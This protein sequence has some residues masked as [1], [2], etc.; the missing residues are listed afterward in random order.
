MKLI[1]VLF[2]T[3][4]SVSPTLAGGGTIKGR[5]TDKDTN[6]PLIGANIVVLG[7]NW[8]AATDIKGFYEIKSIPAGT[9]T[10]RA[11]YIGYKP[12]ELKDI[13]IK[14]FQ[15]TVLDFQLTTDF[16]LQEIVVIDSKYE[17]Q[18]ATNTCKVMNVA[19]ISRLPVSGISN[20]Q[21]LN[22]GISVRGGR[23]TD[24][25]YYIEQIPFQVAGY[26]ACYGTTHN[27]E[28]YNK[29]KE[30]IFKD[31]VLNPLST[32]SV[33]VDYASYSNARRF[34][35]DGYLPPKDAVRVEEFVNYFQ[36]DYPSPDDEHPVSVYTELGI[37]PW[38]NQ[39]MLLHIGLK[40]KELSKKDYKKSNIVFLIDVSGSMMP[41]NKLPLLVKAFKMFTEQLN[42]EDVVSIVV[43]AGSTGLVLPPTKGKDKLK[44]MNM[45]DKLKAGGSTAGGAG[46][47][48]AYKIAEDNFIQD[49]NN[50][51]IWAT[52]GDFNVG[53]SSTSDLVNFLEE[54]RKQGIF[55]T[56]LGFG[57]E[58]LKDNRLE[59]LANNGN[60]HYAY[61]DNLLEAKRVLVDEI[62]ST[63]F[64]IAKD[65][66]IQIEFNPVKIKAYR[67]VGY[68][69]RLLN[70]EDFEDD[71]KDAGEIGS[72]HT[73]T[74]LY[75]LIPQDSEII[76]PDTD[77]RYQKISV[78]DLEKLQSEIGN[79]KIRYKLPDEDE[80]RLMT[81]I[82][83]TDVT[84]EAEISDNF[85]F[86]ASAAMFGMFLR[87]SEFKG[88]SDP[89][90]ISELAR[91]FK[92]T[93]KN[94]YRSEFLNLVELSSKLKDYAGT[95]GK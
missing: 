82:I 54:K 69:N 8:G 25:V 72:G 44:I 7:S 9:Y 4:L 63:L 59:Q 52:D 41:E 58:N 15:V 57:A 92:G 90:L 76:A 62:G 38:N 32:F 88:I 22:S 21:S 78:K 34:L 5:A 84:S 91:R 19:D 1:T 33:D 43:Y 50:R 35:L 14:N 87:D 79:L 71:H 31:A 12:V 94:G 27:T 39:N 48:L 80:S 70:S 6:D 73:V 23:G 51:I 10:I 29:I 28:E 77:L 47:K 67:L 68:E 61:I 30:N 46:M 3:L 60:G 24:A 93:D 36:Y 37:C 66:K 95:I 55:L 89:D 20:I 85:G 75:E 18:N 2:L 40:G 26:S 65:V 16:V 49:G 53:V 11:S 64:T 86:A 83:S 56:V 17:V 81:K 74:A 13:R 45:L 42:D